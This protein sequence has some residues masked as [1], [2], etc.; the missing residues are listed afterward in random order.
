MKATAIT[1]LRNEK[2][3]SILIDSKFISDEQSNR[4]VQSYAPLPQ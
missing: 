2:F 3:S 4:Y 1:Q